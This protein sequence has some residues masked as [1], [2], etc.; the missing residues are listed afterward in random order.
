MYKFFKSVSLLANKP[1][2]IKIYLLFLG[3]FLSMAIEMIGL[4]LIGLYVLAISDISTFVSKVPLE[5]MANLLKSRTDSE[6]ITILSISLILSFIFKSTYSL[7]YSYFEAKIHRSIIISNSTKL[8][9]IYLKK[10]YSYF[11]KQNPQKLVNNINHT[12]KLG[13][14]YIFYNLLL[15]RE[16]ILMAFL[17]FGSIYISWEITISVFSILLLI[18]GLIFYFIKK[19]LSILGDQIVSSGQRILKDLNEGIRGIK[20]SK[21]IK[22]YIYL[23]KTYISGL[24]IRENA[25][26][27]HAIFQKIPRTILETFSVIIVVF[28]SMIL[29]SKFNDPSKLFALLALLSVI[30]IRM[31]PSFA[32][33]NYA[34]SN[35]QYSLS[36]YTILI[37]DLSDGLN[38]ENLNIKRL[39]KNSQIYNFD[40]KFNVKLK[41]LSFS[42]EETTKKSLDN[43]SIEFDSNS[44]IGFVGKSGSGKTTLIDIIIGLLKPESG[45]IEIDNRRVSF[46]ESNNWQSKIGYVPQDVI[47]NNSTIKENIAYGI[48]LEKID[49]KKVLD[50]ILKTELDYL[51][52]SLPMGINTILKDLGKNLSGGE[53]QRFGIA[54]ALYNDPK[55]LILDEA[56]SSLDEVNEQKILNNLKLM[57]KNITIIMIAHKYSTIKFCD[58]VFLFS[59]GKLINSGKPDNLQKNLDGFIRND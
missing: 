34:L 13:I 12:L 51:I 41:N 33:I 55:I 6:I 52:K 3:G 42:Y 44:F 47:L 22:N 37:K 17:V 49:E 9:D 50:V 29:L 28:V 16:L 46:F 15:F 56:T 27:K 11:L 8:Y 45:H 39:V 36:A 48:D 26:L 54:R 30:L 21:I 57:K 20:I 1:Q 19:E 10:P 38:D 7:L 43:I 5:F 25:Q 2:Q 35:L 53:K 31:V 40:K 58:K 18:S 14:N 23:K 24:E 4:G 59:S 32:N